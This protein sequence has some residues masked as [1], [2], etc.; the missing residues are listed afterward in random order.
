MNDYDYSGEKWVTSCEKVINH[1]RF[2]LKAG[3][4][5]INRNA[6]IP[7][8]IFFMQSNPAQKRHANDNVKKNPKKFHL[9]SI[10]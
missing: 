8:A 5:G 9:A 2:L 3:M 10:D 7:K 6:T 4:R 1:P